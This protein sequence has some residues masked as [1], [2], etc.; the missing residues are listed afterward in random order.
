MS[1]DGTE[2]KINA[3]EPSLKGSTPI[4]VYSIAEAVEK[5]NIGIELG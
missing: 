3:A 2:V 5:Q 4:P 1:E